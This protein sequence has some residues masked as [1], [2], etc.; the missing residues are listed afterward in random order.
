MYCVPG[1]V[2]S[3]LCHLFLKIHRPHT[4][5]Y[6]LNGEGWNLQLHLS[7]LVG[8]SLENGPQSLPGIVLSE[9][10][11]FNL[12]RFLTRPRWL[13]LTSPLS[14]CHH[15]SVPFIPSDTELVLP[16]WSRHEST[17]S[18]WP[19][20]L[21]SDGDRNAVTSR[22]LHSHDVKAL[23]FRHPVSRRQM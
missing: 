12:F 17:P 5:Q 8:C 21:L 15:L 23:V 3:V 2:L 16:W 11:A 14:Q 7:S 22:R 4:E 6:H 13:I 20:S 10:T 1:T 18:T 19:F 9:I